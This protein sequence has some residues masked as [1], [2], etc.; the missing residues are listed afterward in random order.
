M[1]TCPR[2]LSRKLRSVQRDSG[3][4]AAAAARA[5]RDGML[6]RIIVTTDAVGGVWRYSLEL[7]RGLI[8]HCIE[9]VLAVL[10][11]APDPMQRDEAA[12]LG[13]RLL[14]TDLP[15]DWLAETPHEIEQAAQTLA[16]VAERFDADTVQLHA[17][18]L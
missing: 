8:E 9:V 6:K 11:P 4:P 2:A 12:A 16:A 7:A 10:G 13:A 17:P 15:L 5:G 18:S 1:G 3:I 14:V